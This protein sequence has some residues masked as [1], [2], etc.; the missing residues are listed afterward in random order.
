MSIIYNNQLSPSGLPP[1]V[2][3]QPSPSNRYQSDSDESPPKR[4]GHNPFSSSKTQSNSNT[5]SPSNAYEN[6]N[7]SGSSSVASDAES[8]PLPKLTRTYDP[9]GQLLREGKP[10]TIPQ[11]TYP[12]DILTTHQMSP[13]RAVGHPSQRNIPTRWALLLAKTT[14]S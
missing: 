5:S 12:I 9:L 14:V 1:S 3:D 10:Q 2:S 4:P 11:Q 8:L 13:K 7:T 6:N